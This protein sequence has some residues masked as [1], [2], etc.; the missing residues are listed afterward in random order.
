MWCSLLAKQ[1]EH[2]TASGFGGGNKLGEDDIPVVKYIFLT[3]FRSHHQIALKSSKLVLCF[4]VL[5][6]VLVAFLIMNS[7]STE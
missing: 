2:T 5:H 7:E 3:A 4:S 6:I 1:R